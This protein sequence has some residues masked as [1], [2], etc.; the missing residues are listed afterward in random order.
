M[1]YL[2]KNLYLQK[3]ENSTQKD[4]NFRNFRKM[5]TIVWVFLQTYVILE[6]T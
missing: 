6:L 3:E 4:K 2:G 5:Y 1:K